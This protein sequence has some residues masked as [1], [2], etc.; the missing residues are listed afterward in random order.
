MAAG[1]GSEQSTATESAYVVRGE[2]PPEAITRSLQAVLPTRHRPI[3]R[4][5]FTVLDTFDGRVRRTGASLTRG[6]VGGASSVAWQPRGGGGQLAVRLKQPVSFA[7]DL[8]DGP[9]QQTLAPVIG[10]R[11][12][13]AQADAEEYGTLLEILDDREKTVARLRIESGRAR[14]A[15]SNHTWRPLPTMLTLTG[16]RG[17]ED[18]YRRLVPLI[19]SRPGIEPCP[20]GLHGMI[21]RQVGAPSDVS[22]LRLDLAP[23]VLA[24]AGARQI[25][26]GL[27]GVLVANE[28]G[29][30]ANL[31]TE[32]LHDFRVA[33]RRTRSLL[34]QIRHVFPPEAEEHFK[35]EFAWMGRLTGP[36]RDLDVLVLALREHREDIPPHDMN[37]LTTCLG[38]RQQQE[39]HA[40]VEALD[41]G[42]Y[43]RLLEE[44]E[45]FLKSPSEPQA[46]NAR[47]PLIEVV[48]RRAWRLSRRIAASAETIDDNTR[49][50]QLHE[51]RISAKKLRYL[52]DV[53]PAFY[54]AADLERIESALKKLQRVLGDFNDAHSQEAR[55]VECG[56]EV[57][58]AGGSAGAVL[59]LGRLAEQSRYRRE[60]L[61][62]EVVEGLVRFR[63]RNT[64]QACR[65][66]FKRAGAAE[67]AR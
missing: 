33:I 17:Y 8:P 26:L 1:V 65:R 62:K 25:H 11:R 57:G 30:R 13:L 41:S 43:R 6:I 23:T 10:V 39:H 48:S 28:P 14:L 53:T 52:I 64:R 9:L 54:D 16:L 27:L 4:H 19:E 56:L 61:R 32:F 20:E 15:A 34:S 40:L 22:E 58:G 29:L 18:A 44:W 5:R 63:R 50:E 46:R 66:A 35:S 67:R 31:D 49:P 24:A 47:L 2:V 3:V 12:L 51:V 60:R 45:A 37:A 21:L 59:A 38:Q 55:L 42:R 7:W 36:P